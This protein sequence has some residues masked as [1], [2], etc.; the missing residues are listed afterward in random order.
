MQQQPVSSKLPQASH[1]GIGVALTILP[2]H[3]L[4]ASPDLLNSNFS[5]DACYMIQ[6]LVWIRVVIAMLNWVQPTT[7]M[8]QSCWTGH[9]PIHLLRA[10]KSLMTY[11]QYD[12]RQNQKAEEH[13]MQL[14][15][16]VQYGR[17]CV[18][19][20]SDMALSYCQSS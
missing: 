15:R 6:Y 9:S 8:A 7:A 1:A 10:L 13:F 4:A 11:G 14:G 16:A 2:T 3:N 18:G 12:S 17:H 5:P 20:E 19:A